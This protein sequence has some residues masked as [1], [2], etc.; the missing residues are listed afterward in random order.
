MPNTETTA[1]P[2]FADLANRYGKQLAY[3][4][5]RDKSNTIPADPATATP[6]ELVS[7]A[8]DAVDF[9]NQCHYWNEAEAMEDAADRLGYAHQAANDAERAVLLRGADEALRGIA[10]DAACEV[11]DAIGDP[12]DF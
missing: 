4:A 11:A 5:G 1:A 7:L 10:Y 12:H 2:T 3:V 8:R 6:D 9:L